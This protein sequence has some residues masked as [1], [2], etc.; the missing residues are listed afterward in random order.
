M[1]LRN[2]EEV[3]DNSTEKTYTN[4]ITL[5]C[6]RTQNA[7]SIPDCFSLGVVSFPVINIFQRAYQVHDLIPQGGIN[8]QPNVKMDC[9]CNKKFEI[10]KK[11]SL[12]IYC[13]FPSASNISY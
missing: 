6:L 13:N 9:V 8:T 5:T 12:W 2:T 7:N 11:K 3:F 10:K 1:L 4:T